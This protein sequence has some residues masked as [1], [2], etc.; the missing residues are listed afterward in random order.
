M[1]DECTDMAYDSAAEWERK[2]IIDIIEARSYHY[3]KTHYEGINCMICN[4]YADIEEGKPETH[5]E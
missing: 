5:G 1:C 2:R 4:I 3:A